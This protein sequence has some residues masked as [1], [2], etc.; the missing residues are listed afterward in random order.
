MFVALFSVANIIRAQ[1]NLFFKFVFVFCNIPLVSPLA[2]WVSRMEGVER[3]SDYVIAAMSFF[4]V[5]SLVATILYVISAVR[6]SSKIK[7]AI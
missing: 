5:I 3:A 4:I 7:N 1:D 2:R 6:T